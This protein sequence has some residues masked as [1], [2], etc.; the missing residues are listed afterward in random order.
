VA[1]DNAKGASL[2]VQHLMEAG[3]RKIGIVSW[4]INGL[5][6]RRERLDGFLSTMQDAAIDVPER[7]LAIV[8]EQS[9]GGVRGVQRLMDQTD[10]PTAIFST[11]M[12]LSLQVLT[13]LRQ[14][15]LRVPDDVSLV[16]F[17]DP[18]WAPLIEPSLTTIATPPFRL[19]K[20]AALRLCRAI[21]RTPSSSSRHSRLAPRLIPRLSVAPPNGR[22]GPRYVGIEQ[23][24]PVEAISR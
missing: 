21:E 18:E 2:A 1:V 11:N 10:P 19:G 23:R 16:G 3:H 24:G 22:K 13:G 5:S 9:D 15:G 4:E 8:D 6:N 14:L 12:E 17:D 7:Y 20:L